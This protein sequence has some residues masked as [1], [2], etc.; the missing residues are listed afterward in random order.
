[1]CLRWIYGDKSQINN[2]LEMQDLI[3]CLYI[4]RLWEVKELQEVVVKAITLKSYGLKQLDRKIE[5]NEG[6]W[7]A[8]EDVFQL[9][10]RENRGVLEDLIDVMALGTPVSK[11]WMMKLAGE[12]KAGFVAALP[13]ERHQRVL[14]L[15][16]CKNCQKKKGNMGEEGEKRECLGCLDVLE[17]EAGHDAGETG[18]QAGEDNSS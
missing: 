10:G 4:A 11:D 2:G 17:V 6:V 16:L 7:N 13:L 18:G 5:T 12:S 1:M 15:C 8:V 9:L 3:N 14:D